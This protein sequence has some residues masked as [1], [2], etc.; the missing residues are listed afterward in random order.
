MT[1]ETLPSPR[2]GAV[3]TQI[4]PEASG[5]EAPGKLLGGVFA[6]SVV[7][8]FMCLIVNRYLPIQEGWFSYYAQLMHAGKLPYR[9][10]YFFTQPISLGISWLVYSISDKMIWMRYYGLVERLC[11]T[12]ALYYLI[13][14]RFSAKASFWATVVPILVFLSYRSE[15]FF[16]YLVTCCLFFVLSLIC[17]LLAHLKPERESALLL[18][19]G[20]LSS[21]A[22]FSKQSNGLIACA[23]IFFLAAAMSRSIPDAV[24]RLLLSCAGWAIPAAA[25]VWWLMYHRIFRLYLQQVFFGASASKGG[26]WAIL[27]SFLVRATTPFTLVTL[28]LFTAYIGWKLRKRSFRLDP[29]ADDSD[30]GPRLLVDAAV[31]AACVLITY[32]LPLPFGSGLLIREFFLWIVRLLFWFGLAAFLVCLVQLFRRRFQRDPF[33]P[34]FVIGAF[35][36]AYGCGLSYLVEQQA[37]LFVFSG[38]LAMSFDMLKAPKVHL[39]RDVVAICACLLCLVCWQKFAIAFDWTAWQEGIAETTRASHWPRLAGYR[40]DAAVMANIDSVLDVIGHASQPGDAVFTFPFM[41]IFNYVTNRPQPTFAPVHYWD[42]CP[43]AVAEADSRRVL[44]AKPKVIVFMGFEEDLWS[45]HEG[46]FRGGRR[47]GQRAI[48][49]AIDDL[50]RSGDYVHIRSWNGP[51]YEVPVHVWARRK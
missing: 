43:D 18:L 34:I 31:S 47:S 14:R 45:L 17:L 26:V 24:R 51:F 48:Q 41:P 40:T 42:V 12:A 7:G 5:V 11:L 19:A 29:F 3:E 36:W 8:L 15:A 37:I 46:A 1:V 16:T 2:S 20:V 44:D 33:V 23:V 6:V 9:D 4:V 25:V 30:S 32:F 22:F 10:F 38:V 21:L 50:V 39:K 27:F 49:Q 35:S 28:L 13:S